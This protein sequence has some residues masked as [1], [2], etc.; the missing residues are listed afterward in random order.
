MTMAVMD[1]QRSDS[2]ALPLAVDLDGTLIRADLFTEAMLAF[3]TAKPWRLPQLLFWLLVKGRAY[4]KAKLADEVQVAPEDLP[5]DTRLVGWLR[6]E[7][8]KGRTIVLATACDRKAAQPVADYLGVFDETFASD[9]VTNLKSSRKA[10]RLRQAFPGGFVYAGNESAD[11]KV[12]AEAD[13]AVVVNAGKGLTR[14]AEKS[15]AV[16][17]TFASDGNVLKALIKAIRP[18]QWSKNVLVFLPILV[19]QGW[20]DLSGFGNAL[21]AF[22]AVSFAASSLYIVNDAS[23]ISADRAH[24]RKRRRPFASGALSPAVGLIAA[25]ALCVGG[26]VLGALADVLFFVVA[27]MI[28]SA[29]YTFWLKRKLLADVFMLAALYV[30]RVVLGA[31]ATGHEAS[32]WLLGFCGFF[33]LSLALVKRV[34]EVDVAAAAGMK[35]IGRRGYNAMDGQILKMISVAAGMVSA[36]VLALYVQSDVAAD[37][38]GA[39]FLLWSLPVAALFWL[40]RVWMLTERGKMHDDPVVFAF[41]DRPSL[42]LGALTGV[43]FLAAVVTPQELIEALIG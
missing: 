2:A 39:P 34:T 41:R 38:Y 28:M 10:E 32:P 6:E 18:Q 15:F 12:W 27:Y 21:L 1:Q 30:I 7:R 9:G 33:F 20:S 37:H 35:R 23:D 25:V 13:G 29:S 19:G 14:R 40:C 42:I 22:F 11:L 4:T 31:A 26:L 5:Y 24:P 17:R 36:M 3:A 8:A 16:E 43:A